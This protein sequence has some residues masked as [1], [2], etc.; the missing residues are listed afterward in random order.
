MFLPPQ[1]T[2][3]LIREL[4]TSTA[5]TL[6]MINTIGDSLLSGIRSWIATLKRY[7]KREHTSKLEKLQPPCQQMKILLQH[8]ANAVQFLQE[9]KG[10]RQKWRDSTES[11]LSPQVPTKDTI[12]I[13]HQFQE[14]IR[15]IDI[16][17]FVPSETSRVLAS[18]A[19]LQEDWQVG[20]VTQGGLSQQV[21]EDILHKAVL[22][23]VN[24]EAKF[25]RKPSHSSS[26]SSSTGK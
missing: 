13:R 9:H 4:S 17:A 22:G 25:P 5:D 23:S 12:S 1:D 10:S 11:S 15:G 18:T 19:G 7:L 8:Q 14:L 16:T 21:L 6:A 2:E 26:P 3:K 24:A 20:C